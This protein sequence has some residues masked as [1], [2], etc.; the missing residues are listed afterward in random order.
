MPGMLHAIVFDFDGVLVDSEGVH[1]A[2]IRDEA[3]ALGVTLDEPLYHRV[4]IGYDDRD[5]FR[6][7]LSMKAG[8]PPDPDALET[9]DP[10]ELAGLCERKQARFEAMIGSGVEPLPGVRELL[11]E[12]AAALPIAVASG[13]TRRDIE[14]IL[15]GLGWLDR[16][17]AIVT[18]DDVARSKPHPETYALAVERLAARHGRA[19]EP[20]GC[21]AIE[22][23]APGLRSA[24]DAGLRTLGVCTTG[25]AEALA[26]ADRVEASLA[27][28]TLRDLEGWFG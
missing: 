6:A 20:G 12:A 7:V 10:R 23:T 22:D 4:F 13:A 28:V 19:V 5:A 24:I 14:A 15:T 2:A 26:K 1:F 11:D 16:F 21:L 18:A 3:A 17:E 25:T 27:G 9:I 8:G